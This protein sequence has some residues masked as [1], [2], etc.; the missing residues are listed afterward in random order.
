MGDSKILSNGSSHVNL[1]VCVC[2]KGGR[3]REGGREHVGE[4]KEERGTKLSCLTSYK[5]SK[6]FSRTFLGGSV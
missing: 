3:G 2:T 1:C 4:E 6:F 5:P